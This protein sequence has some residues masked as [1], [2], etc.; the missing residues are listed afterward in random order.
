MDL[1]LITSFNFDML[2]NFLLYTTVINKDFE[3]IKPKIKFILYDCS[4][5][6]LEE[7]MLRN[8][9]EFKFLENKIDTEEY[10][11]FLDCANRK[12]IYWNCQEIK[13]RENKLNYHTFE[14]WLIL[15]NPLITSEK[16]VKEWLLNKISSYYKIEELESEDSQFWRNLMNMVSIE[17]YSLDDIYMTVYNGLILVYAQDEIKQY[18]HSFFKSWYNQIKIKNPMPKQEFKVLKLE[19]DK[20]I[21]IVK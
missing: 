11:S 14:N 2:Y 12:N 1:F 5:T 16:Q 10:S 15:N 17:D 8:I 20:S 6:E 19:K 18:N 4:F 13:P 3:F 7:Q 9:P 21:I